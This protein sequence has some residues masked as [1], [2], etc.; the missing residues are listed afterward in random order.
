LWAEQGLGDEVFYAGLLPQVLQRGVSVTL[1]ADRRLHPALA[2]AFPSIR[3]LDRQQPPVGDF[4]AQAPIGDLA[5][6]LALDKESLGANRKPYFQAD[7]ARKATL[8]A[9]HPVFAAGP[10]CG[11]AWRS[12]NKTFG[13][14][15]SLALRQLAPLFA[16]PGLQFVNLQYGA[17]DAEIEAVRQELGV[18]IHRIEDLDLF[19]DVEGLLALVDACSFVV[20]SSNVT[21]HLAGSLGQRTGVLLPH[22]GQARLWYWHDGAGDSFWYPSLRLF[23]QDSPSDWQPAV[24][25][26]A[27]WVKAIP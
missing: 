5:W 17:V 14:A 8:V 25:A 24:D 19:N 22:G 6:L 27:Q 15:K 11:V 26:C 16:T 2:R 1:S 23:R 12:A 9:S 3:L 13:A 21:A 4:D 20:T 10:V 7:P 18:T